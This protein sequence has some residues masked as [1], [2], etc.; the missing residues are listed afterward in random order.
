M[1]ILAAN[2]RHIPGSDWRADPEACR[3][4]KIGGA[5]CESQAAGIRGCD[6]VGMQS[7]SMAEVEIEALQSQERPDADAYRTDSGNHAMAH[8]CGLDPLTD[9][10]LEHGSQQHRGQACDQRRGDRSSEPPPSSAGS[11][12]NHRRRMPQP[13][14]APAGDV[15]G[16]NLYLRECAESKERLTTKWG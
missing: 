8:G 7:H 1:E 11:K 14:R 2:A 15:R 13:D 12:R 4:H 10:V 9:R 5:N 3:A 16:F 6:H